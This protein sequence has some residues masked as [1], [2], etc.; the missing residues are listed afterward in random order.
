[1]PDHQPELRRGDVAVKRSRIVVAAVLLIAAGSAVVLRTGAGSHDARIAASSQPAGAHGGLSWK[2]GEAYV[3]RFAWENET[4]V[5]SSALAPSGTTE[6]RGA[7]AFEGELTLRC[8]GLRGDAYLFGARASSLTKHRAELLGKDVFADEAMA[9]N[10]FEGRETFVEIDPRGAVHAM[11]FPHDAPEMFRHTMR[12]MLSQLHVTI[13][14]GAPAVWSAVEPGPAGSAQVAWAKLGPLTYTRTRDHYDAFTALPPRFARDHE[15]ALES[16][17]SLTL[18]PE[19]FVQALHDSEKLVVRPKGDGAPLLV[20]RSTFTLDHLRTEPFDAPES[21]TASLEA[22]HPG[23][24]EGPIADAEGQKLAQ[25]AEG[26]TVGRI[27]EQMFVVGIGQHVSSDFLLRSMALLRLHPE[28]ASE[29]LRLAT[30]KSMP[31]AGRELAADVLAA[32]GTTEAQTALRSL[33]DAVRSDGTQHRHI[34]QRVGFVTAPKPETVAA[35]RSAYAAST[36]KGDADGRLAAAYTLGA[37]A[38]HLADRGDRGAARSIT[39]GLARDLES[40]KSPSDRRGLLAALGNAGAE[41]TLPTFRAQ[42]TDEDPSVRAEVAHGLRKIETPEAR[43]LLYFMAADT[44][45]QVSRN[46]LDSLGQ[47]P[48]GDAEVRR[49]T[50]L[51]ERGAIPRGAVPTLLTVLSKHPTPAKEVEAALRALAARMPGDAD[52]QGRVEA[53]LTQMHGS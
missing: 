13:D 5:R 8:F 28:L 35:V 24:P 27:S 53:I 51:M 34:L 30:D 50:E 12:A 52:V 20:E 10:T 37:T 29:V 41:S 16:R 21:D 23:D 1:V 9:K 47:Q 14:E 17:S 11:Y 2:K 19:G 45:G 39:D 40:S 44:D 48:L 32:A 6:L 22:W 42:S 46:A 43:D 38:A 7:V 31:P 25:L 26:M 33:V 15:D 49:L 36:A 3:Y 4:T 18:A